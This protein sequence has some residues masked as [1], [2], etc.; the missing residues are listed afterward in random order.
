MSLLPLNIFVF[1][2]RNFH[3]DMLLKLT[4]NSFMTIVLNKLINKCYKS[5]SVFNKVNTDI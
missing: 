3:K 4:W 2:D 5:F 1:E